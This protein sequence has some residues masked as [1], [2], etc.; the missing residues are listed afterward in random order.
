MEFKLTERDLSHI[1]TDLCEISCIVEKPERETEKTI[2]GCE[3]QNSSEVNICSRALLELPLELYRLT[4]LRVLWLSNNILFDLPEE[5][6]KL[7]NLE[8]LGLAWN[9]F[10]GIQVF[11]QWI[12]K[13]N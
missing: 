7:V 1:Y 10:K 13:S 2:K 4:W 8:V 9:H 6:S 5:F 3:S 11:S 12:I